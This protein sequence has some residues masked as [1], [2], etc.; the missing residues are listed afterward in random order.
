MLC[1]WSRAV[2]GALAV[3]LLA[4]CGPSEESSSTAPTTS[5]PT[6]AV[7]P[8]SA[9]L[10][11]TIEVRYPDGLAAL[12]DAVFV[13][14]DDG[15]VV[16]I[17]T[18][19]AEVVADVRIDTSQEARRYCQGIGSDG[20][21]L[22]ACS[23]G[24]E[25]TDV[26]RLDPE[27]LE[28]TAKLKVDKLFD[29]LAL[30]VVAGR[31]WVL[32]GTGDRL[33]MIDADSGD[34]TTMPLG[35][36]CFQLAATA[37]RVYATCILTDEVVALDVATGEIVATAGVTHPINVAALVD[38][39]WVSGGG[40][41]LRLTA[42]LKPVAEYAGLTAG[43]DGDIFATP[44]AVWVR[45]AKGFLFRIDPRTDTVAA[46]YSIDPVPSGGSALATGDAVWLTSFDDD[47]VFRLDPDA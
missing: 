28:V 35:R 20:T 16:R 37:T 34:T 4:A 6:T 3:M 29:Q 7:M 21:S 15:H 12:G 13:K 40:E 32:T 41:L 24:P 14:T 1:G 44:D 31:V 39:V 38:D 8:E 25:T 23:A 47:L 2:A 46:R 18:D 11:A 42:D 26:Y 9:W 30:P 43:L 22:W 27:T 19:T 45:Q 17:E 5:V 36:R 33:T 10:T